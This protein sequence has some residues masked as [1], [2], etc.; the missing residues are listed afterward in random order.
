MHK[1]QT[2]LLNDNIIK[3]MLSF[4]VPFFISNVF[5]Q[6][7]STVDTIIVGHNLGDLSLAAMGAGAPIQYLL[8]GLA[9]AICSG[10]SIVVGRSF[11]SGDEELLKKSVAGTLVLGGIITIVLAL[12]AHFTIL[13]LLQLLDTPAE[14]LE[15]TFAY[16]YIITIFIGVLMA[17]N[18]L[19]GILRAVGDSIV[20]LIFLIIAS[21][22][23]IF[24]DL[25]FIKT[26]KMGIKGAATATIVA[27]GVSALLCMIYIW[28][29]CRFLIP[30]RE[31]FVFD[32]KLYL[33]LASQGISMGLMSALVSVGTVV[34][35][36]AINSLGY[37]IIAGHMAAKKLFSFTMMPLSAIC[38]SLATFVAQNKGANKPDRIKVA[39]RYANISS[40]IWSIFITFMVYFSAPFMVKALTGSSEPAVIDY[41]V[42]FI[43]IETLFYLVLGPLLNLRYALQSIG[44]KLLPL[45]SSVIEL[46]GKVIFTF[47][48]FP[49]TG[50][51]G[52]IFCEPIIWCF[53]LAQLAFAYMKDPYI[54]LKSNELLEVNTKE[55]RKNP[56]QYKNY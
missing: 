46:V 40:T 36:I 21:I 19:S 28:K 44:Q 56:W 14:I 1:T 16:I 48:I 29:R 8:V 18:V 53:M 51:L 9:L 4:A 38:T 52:V 39:V 6:L 20:P 3:G 26:F 12:L 17:F 43:R 24:L 31:H 2:D 34:I 7:Y 13:P 50:A 27:Q 55:P 37:L 42:T 30:S 33:D 41:G 23:N 5:Q 54:N 32:K 11:G 25:L 45:V 15:D 10:M 49:F 22:I 35:Q 47:W